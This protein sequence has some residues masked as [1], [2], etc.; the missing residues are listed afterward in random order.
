MND[1]NVKIV[2]LDLN[3]ILPNRFQPRIK[4]NEE[5]II[6]LSESI[7]LHGV[8]QP[9][10]VRPISDKYEIVVGERRYKAAVLA[11]LSTIPARV[12]D[13]DDKASIE[14][15]LIENL[16]RKDLNPMEEA[17]SY[18]KTLNMGYMTQEQLASKLGKSQSAIANKIRLLNL[19]DDVQEALMDE[20]ISERHARSLLKV[21]TEKQQ[22]LL[23]DRIINERLTVRKLDEIIKNK[24]FDNVSDKKD[25]EEPTKEI[26]AN[27]DTTIN[28]EAQND[29]IEL[30]E[31]ASIDDDEKE[32]TDL[33]L[34]DIIDSNSDKIVDISDVLSVFEGSKV[35]SFDKKE[36]KIE[37]K[38]EESKE[39]IDNM[40]NS[41]NIG[42]TNIFNSPQG[43]S[44]F[45][46]PSILESANNTD[47]VKSTPES[48]GFVTKGSTIATPEPPSIFTSSVNM[49]NLL[50][51]QSQVS[52]SIN[53][54]PIS[55]FGNVGIQP[56]SQVSQ[57]TIPTTSSLS[58]PISQSNQPQSMFTSLMNNSTSNEQIDK[59]TLNNF[60]D[61]TFIDGAKQESNT[62]SNTID[63]QVFAKF[64]DPDF[65]GEVST[66]STLENTLLTPA[67]S[68][69]AP[70]PQVTPAVEPVSQV[71][72]VAPVSQ[73]LDLKPESPAPSIDVTNNSSQIDLFNPASKPDL[74][75]P[76]DNQSA[77][78]VENVS[79]F[80]QILDQIHP[81][82]TSASQPS[83]ISNNVIPV[84][85][86][87]PELTL[88][89]TINSFEKAEEPISS[90][91]VEPQPLTSPIFVTSSSPVQSVAPST[92]II[93][94]PNISKLLSVDAEEPST[95]VVSAQTPLTMGQ[96]TSN[97]LSAADNLTSAPV[98]SFETQP[99]IITDYT[100][101]YDPILPADTRPVEPSI[102]FKTILNMI[103][104]LNDKIES[105][106]YT[107]DT[108]EID[109]QDIYQVIFNITKK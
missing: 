46:N 79:P 26:I 59:T 23:L 35:D 55:I 88:D 73:L 78:P 99:I 106:G 96:N 27:S 100:K 76:M 70:Q 4:F 10:I 57:Q 105:Y 43:T 49:N 86:P 80:N 7:K 81:Q 102:D 87:Q 63:E 68:T 15:A 93:D 92:P 31:N 40:N 19:C 2:E 17:I 85:Q 108:E 1:N 30:I 74:M 34:N 41:Q 12:V 94:N 58:Q 61:P 29:K 53:N 42:D 72:S 66:N 54:N 5:S 60:L 28:N 101:Q 8:L 95:E 104:E 83:I 69:V 3:D 103:R 32:Q 18:K 9:I 91:S 56:E 25:D 62:S 71:E 39:E 75:A 38:E 24:E 82:E 48:E 89:D 16:Q 52:S 50:A 47:Q 37:I 13:L 65:G 36:E 64:I 45:F 51:P 21:E 67:A 107:I 90:P 33:K 84:E 11:D 6:E 44:R 97:I 98:S 22:Q 14:I 77:A 20:K 109:L